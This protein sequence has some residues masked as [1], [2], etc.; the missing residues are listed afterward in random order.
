MKGNIEKLA[1]ALMAELSRSNVSADDIRELLN[2]LLALLK[3]DESENN[4]DEDNDNPNEDSVSAESNK[5]E[6]L[7]A[8]DKSNDEDEI[9][10]D[11]EDKENQANDLN[12]AMAELIDESEEFKKPGSGNQMEIRQIEN[13]FLSKIPNGLLQLAKRIGRTGNTGFHTYGKFLTASKSDIA[14]ITTGD[15]LNSLLPSEIAKLSCPDTENIFYRDFAEKCLQV[16]ASASSSEHPQEHHEGPVI[17]CL[18]TSSSMIGWKVEA[19]TALTMA[20]AIIAQRRQRKVLIVNYSDSHEMMEIKNIHK[21]FR[22]LSKFL[23]RAGRGGNSENSMF[24]WL[25]EEILPVSKKFSSGDVLCVSDFGWEFLSDET[26][27]LIHS[28]KSKGMLFY[29]LNVGQCH[30]ENHSLFTEDD[31]QM[32]SVCDSLWHYDGKVCHEIHGLIS[33]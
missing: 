6:N 16:F 32:L 14:G 11:E 23:S 9:E 5:R 2:Y 10:G 27:E 28:E 26:K 12:K 22:E 4:H 33:K 30:P 19:A 13:R 21:Q 25:F 15:N 31:D 17:V 8:A 29:G 18:D 24:H 3:N 1:K 20:V 7:N